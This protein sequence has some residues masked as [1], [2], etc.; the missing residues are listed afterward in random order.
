MSMQACFI[1][2]VETPIFYYV[3]VQAVQVPSGAK[4]V[5]DVRWTGTTKSLRLGL[6]G[7]RTPYAECLSHPR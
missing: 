3:G 2:S 6:Q 5:E 4:N 7:G 1:A